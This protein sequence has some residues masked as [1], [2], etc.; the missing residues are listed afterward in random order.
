MAKY[1][2]QESRE[3]GRRHLPRCHREF[4]VLNRAKAANVPGNRHV[5]RRVRE[6]ELGT[7]L[8]KQRLIGVGPG[9]IA[10]NQP[11]AADAPN[12]A[13]PGHRRPGCNLRQCIGRIIIV[14]SRQLANQQID[15]R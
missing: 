2:P 10:A 14:C 3:F 15:L 8:A 11:V 7:P 12:I 4:A 1:R 6:H 5:I 9:R 13:R